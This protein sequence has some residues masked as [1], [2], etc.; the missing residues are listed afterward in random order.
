[1]LLAGAGASAQGIGDLIAAALV[2]AGLPIHEA[3]ARINMVDSR[4]LVTSD[5]PSLEPFKAAFARP[6]G[7]VAAFA[8]RDR[9]CIS[10]AEA[11][12]NIRPTILLGTSG[13]GGLFTEEVVRAMAAANE[14]PIVFPLSNPTSKSECTAEEAIR[15]SDGRA[16]VATGSPFGPVTYGGR[17]FRIGQCNNAFIFPGVGL[18][19]WVG[20]VRRV[21]DG[22]FLD[23]A[24][25][26][27]DQVTDA[28]L[29]SGAVYPDLTRIRSCSRAIAGAV[30]RRAFQERHA[31]LE[32]LDDLDQRIARAMWRPEY[33]PIRYVGVRHRDGD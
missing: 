30:I 7:D 21:V 28:D 24:R 19:L 2:D 11:I 15:W 33:R 12:A 20:R 29:A 22:M 1:M 25:M 4:G 23:A 8:C 5:R 18:G 10:L 9:S 32:S 26:L 3:R 16:I 27:A 17:T 6:A 31:S 14:R 13:T